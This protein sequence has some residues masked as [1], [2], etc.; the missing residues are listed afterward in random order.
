M[1]KNT[2][3]SNSASRHALRRNQV[4]LALHAFLH[5]S[6]TS[7]PFHRPVSPV[8]SGSWYDSLRYFSPLSLTIVFRSVMLH[9]LTVQ[10]A[11]S[12]SDRRYGLSLNMT[13]WQAMAGSA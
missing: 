9:V 5:Y 13:F 1:P 6:L 2:Q 4:S 3:N 12:T 10:H 11:S 7:I 8:A